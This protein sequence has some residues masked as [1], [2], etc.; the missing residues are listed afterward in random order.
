M[1]VR[2]TTVLA[3]A[4]AAGLASAGNISIAITP[5]LEMRDGTLTAE[6][7]V[8]NGGD[9]AAHS[10][11]PMLVFGDHRVR[12]DARDDL[13][14]GGTAKASL[15]LPVGELGPGRWLYSVAV[16]YADANGYPFQALHVGLLT[17]SKPAPAK[18]AVSKIEA[19]PISRNGTLGIDLKNLAGVA[20]D[21][22][23]RVVAPEGIEVTQP[24]GTIPVAPW[25]EATARVPVVNRTALAGSRYPVFVAAEYDDEG[26][27]QTGLGSAILEIQA[28]R[29]FFQSQ[30]ATLWIVAAALALAWLAFMAGQFATGRR[31]APRA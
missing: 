13:P 10:V 8:K 16:D 24:G 23:V 9:E 7:E 4:L 26:I 11:S 28:P 2:L 6:V 12:A 14:P 21:A 31:T 17:V 30:R 29:S 25:G 19:P 15:A 27:H 18:I 20:R 22:R 1:I 5:T 3:L